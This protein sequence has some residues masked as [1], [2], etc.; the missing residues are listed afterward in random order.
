MCTCECLVTTHTD[1][2]NTHNFLLGKWQNLPT[3]WLPTVTSSPHHYDQR[4]HAV[5]DVQCRQWIHSPTET[6]IFYN[7][8]C[9]TVNV[10]MLTW[11]SVIKSSWNS[12]LCCITS[13]ERE[14]LCVC[15]DLVVH[16]CLLILG[17][18]ILSQV[19]T[20][21]LPWLTCGLEF[22]PK[23]MYLRI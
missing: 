14:V 22:H 16:K 6:R 23:D 19:T 5:T 13:T 21:V 9:F 11:S 1:K 10:T 20:I 7:P 4:P 17:C 3:P 18:D 12:L 8:T 2:V 15:C